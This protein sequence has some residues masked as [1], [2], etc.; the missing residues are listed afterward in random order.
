MIYLPFQ[1]HCLWKRQIPLW[2]R[3]KVLFLLLH[4]LALLLYVC[5]IYTYPWFFGYKYLLPNILIIPYGLGNP[6][7]SY[8]KYNRVAKTKKEETKS[9]LFCL[10]KTDNSILR[11]SELIEENFICRINIFVLYSSLANNNRRRTV[12]KD[13]YKWHFK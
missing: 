3:N 11:K 10:Q 1:V 5:G 2:A 6:Y 12:C 4:S 8:D 7:S 9:K 13:V